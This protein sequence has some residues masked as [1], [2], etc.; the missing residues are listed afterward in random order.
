MLKFN[1]K[2]FG[3]IVSSLIMFIAIISVSTV[4]VIS[5]KN[6]VFQTNDA[7]NQQNDFITQKIKTTISISNVFYNSTSNQVFIYVKNLGETSLHT[8]LFDLF[9]DEE[10]T[11]NFLVKKA[12]DLTTDVEILTPQQTLVIIANKT[13]NTGSHSLT[14]VSEFGNREKENFN[15]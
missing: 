5:F 12:E 8:K 10:Y 3:S 13:L 7:I 4:V 15:I 9:L 2:G 11:S 14:L 6:Q 1:K